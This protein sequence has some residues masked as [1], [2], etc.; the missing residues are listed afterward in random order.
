MVPVS[1]YLGQTSQWIQIKPANQQISW[2]RE[3]KFM[4]D[5]LVPCNSMVVEHM[6]PISLRR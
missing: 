2:S 5:D 1:L 4:S 3:P 6:P